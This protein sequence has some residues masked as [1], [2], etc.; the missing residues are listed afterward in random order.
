M[1]DLAGPCLPQRVDRDDQPQQTNRERQDHGEHLEEAA[2]QFPRQNTGARGQHAE[3][4]C[5]A[6]PAH[7]EGK[8][9]QG[10]QADEGEA[11]PHERETPHAEAD[12][13]AHDVEYVAASGEGLKTDGAR[14]RP[15]ARSLRRSPGREKLQGD[16]AELLD[17]EA[18]LPERPDG[19]EDRHNG[20]PRREAVD[21]QAVEIEG[22]NEGGKALPDAP[23]D[24]G[25][26]EGGDGV[27]AGWQGVGD[28]AAR[29]CRDDGRHNGKKISR[30]HGLEAGAVSMHA[31]EDVVSAESLA[32]SYVL[33][34]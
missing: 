18:A 20:L 29:G 31:V 10:G 8:T 15:H 11:E 27:G 12:E 1:E 17:A 30:R 3:G 13:E 21:G 19:E 4:E 7:V 5:E 16:A 6:P 33:G 25:G 9:L 28:D 22:E 24:V 26:D 32:S 14:A 23:E 34:R 2:S